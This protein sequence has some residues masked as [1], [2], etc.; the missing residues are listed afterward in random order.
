MSSD[1]PPA[2]SPVLCARN[3]GKSYI[4]YPSEISRLRAMITGRRSKVPSHCALEGLDLD[5]YP[6]ECLGI[7]G[8]NGAGKST[9]LQLLCGTLEPTTGTVDTRG[10]ISPLLELAS[11]FSPDFTGRE[12]VYQK[13]AILGLTKKQTDERFD[14]ISSF[15]DIG[16]F[17]DRPVRIYSSGMLARL[18]FAVS[19]HVDADILVLDEILAVGDAA[20]QRKCHARIAQMRQDGTAILLVSHSTGA[21]TASCNRAI[22]IDAGQRLIESDPKAVISWYHRLLDASAD[23]QPQIRAQILQQHAAESTEESSAHDRVA[24]K[25]DAPNPTNSAARSKAIYNPNLVSKSVNEWDRRG[26]RIEQV[27]LEDAHGHRVNTLVRHE[28]YQLV[29]QVV[30]E[31]EVS[32]A[33]FG[34][35]I[36]N[37]KGH[38]IYGCASSPPGEGIGPVHAGHQCTVRFLFRASLA[39]STYFCCAGVLGPDESHTAGE[40]VY[41]HR[42]FDADVFRIQASKTPLTAG[43][44]D[45]SVH[46]HD[47]AYG[48]SLVTIEHQLSHNP[49]SP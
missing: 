32:N 5:I 19:I 41:L 23:D 24:R 11:G 35:F 33:R 47:D 15:A 1:S 34:M 44:A 30:F 12:N 43:F 20:F 9:L 7:V 28:T 48:Q 16:P 29:Y 45:L 25:T 22:L 40:E 4:M 42:V 14:Q 2:P 6:G 18:A 37:T 26:A 13:A 3:L 31:R 36:R 8:R 49:T 27:H 21:I 10:R 38:D 39:Q 17:L 46:E